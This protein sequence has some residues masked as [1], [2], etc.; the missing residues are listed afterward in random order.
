MLITE[1]VVYNSASFPDCARYLGDLYSRRVNR[2]ALGTPDGT[3][4]PG[5]PAGAAT[6][7]AAM[8]YPR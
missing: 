8:P 5:A 7:G 6:P 3:G 2:G 4:S 1:A